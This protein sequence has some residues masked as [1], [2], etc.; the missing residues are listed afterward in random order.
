M[1]KARP[2]ILGAGI[3]GPKS[4]G[5]KG[6]SVE[7]SGGA[8]KAAPRRASSINGSGFGGIEIG[9]R[10]TRRAAPEK[11]GQHPPVHTQGTR[12]ATTQG[13]ARMTAAS[14][15]KPTTRASYPRSRRGK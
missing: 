13:P 2:E 5:R 15:R 10:T 11:S 12:K 3:P 8:T 14:R 7:G 1:A 4:T 9:G 6:L